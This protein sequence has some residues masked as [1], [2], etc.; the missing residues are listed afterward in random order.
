MEGWR[1]G[2][3]SFVARGEGEGVQGDRAVGR[4]A[5]SLATPKGLTAAAKRADSEVRAAGVGRRAARRTGPV[6][7]LDVR[8]RAG[9]RERERAKTRCAGP[10]RHSMSAYPRVPGQAQA[11]PKRTAETR[12]PTA[13]WPRRNGPP[14]ACACQR[15]RAQRRSGALSR[16]RRSSPTRS[17]CEMKSARPS[18]PTQK[19]C[20]L[21]LP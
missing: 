21:L 3:P 16:S 19:I 8:G 6:P 1:R 20:T 2:N 14:L 11:A 4:K 18:A 5:R 10:G 9:E 17:T 15:L 13:R 12:Q 7:R